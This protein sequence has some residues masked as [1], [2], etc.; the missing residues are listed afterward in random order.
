MPSRQ[1]RAFSP[2]GCAIR[3]LL[4][5]SAVAFSGRALAA[6]P[7]GEKI[8]RQQC[9][10]C[11]GAKGEGTKEDYPKP[12]AG[13][14][15]VA[16]LAKLIA[17]T[18]PKDDPGSCVGADA[19]NVAAYIYDAF[20]SKTAQERLKPPRI[21]LSRLTVRQHQNA[22]ADLVASFRTPGQWD[23]KR[24]LR[25]EYFNGRGFRND[26]RAIDRLDTEIRFD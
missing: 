4:V 3:V 20:Y 22:I 13:D 26:Q 6:D 7:A 2:S 18:M 1:P 10:S 11:H 8:Y 25:G 23:D 5:A 15:S 24:G 12:L 17:K 16:Q 21:E 19:D 14:R 9:A